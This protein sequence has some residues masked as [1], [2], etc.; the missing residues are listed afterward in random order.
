[1]KI[2]FTGGGT[3][4]HFYP[5]I[6]IAQAIKK[7]AAEKKVI[8]PR[9]YF[10]S[11]QPYNERVLFEQNIKFIPVL[12]GKLRR[13]QS[14]SSRFLNFFDWFKT[15]WGSLQ[16]LVK[17][18]VLYP[19][20]VVGKGGYASFPPLL[21]ARLLR[22]PV[23]IHESD[24]RPGRVNHWAGRF[25]ARIAVSYPEALKYFPTERTA[26][27]GNPLREDILIATPTGAHAYLQL[28]RD[29][30]I[31]FVIG[32]SQGANKINQLI[33]DILPQLLERYQ[34]I[35]QTGKN[36]FAE[37]KQRVNFV[38]KDNPLANRYKIFDYL[39]STALRMTA[40]VTTLVITRAGSALFE[41]A[42]WGLPAIVIPIP[43]EVS[44]DQRTNAFTYARSGAAVVIEEK[45]L[46]ASILKSEID[47]IITDDKLRDEMIAGAKNF[48]RPK[49][50]ATIAKE[51]LK[52][53][54]SH[55]E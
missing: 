19:D 1:M 34:L 48:A 24:S 28:S 50:A 39:D 51:I 52:I 40:G 47:R 14:V 12:A 31:I 55:E 41:L 18:F 35:H 53:A 33:V 29:L 17:V 43:E 54:L 10:M 30:P 11:D 4:G 15:A 8:E 46:T 26:L 49:A 44:H 23:V 6:A 21:A 2:L 32:G 27:T 36:N 45:N 20:V 42:N 13:D 16:A 3:G 7:E 5:I 38:L 25:A 37:L 22:L 9:L